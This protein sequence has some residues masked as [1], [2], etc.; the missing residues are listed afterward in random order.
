MSDWS[1]ELEF[2][3]KKLG[4]GAANAVRAIRSA[5]DDAP[6][7]I[8]AYRGY[9][10]AVQAHVYGRVV[11]RIGVTPSS[12]KDTVLTNLLNTYRR[13]DADPLPRAEVA[14]VFGSGS[15][16][17]SADNEGYFGGWVKSEPAE[18]KLEWHGYDVAF[19]QPL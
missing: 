15:S 8:L 14:V 12:D 3:R 17:M 13:A 7:E 10:N 16:A 2:L 11:K 9:G 18:S 4:V 19:G 6:Y 5:I 1:I